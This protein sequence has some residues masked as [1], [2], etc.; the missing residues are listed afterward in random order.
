[1]TEYDL[2]VSCIPQIARIAIECR[3]L[4]RQDYEKFKQETMEHVPE[5][6]KE[7]M[8]KVLITMDSLVVK[9]QC[10]SIN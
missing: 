7:F 6:V 2:F 9:R 1:M 10:D 3:R 4:D 8:S 5:T